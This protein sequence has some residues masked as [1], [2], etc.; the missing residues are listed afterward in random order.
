M[1]GKNLFL[2]RWLF[3]FVQNDITNALNPDTKEIAAIDFTYQKSQPQHFSFFF[4][5]NLFQI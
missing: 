3:I 1:H 4:F 5:F 2:W